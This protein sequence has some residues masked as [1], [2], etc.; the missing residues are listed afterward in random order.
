MR[1]AQR[2]PK[3]CLVRRDVR[4]VRADASL[5]HLPHRRCRLVRCV[6]C[7]AD[8][9]PPAAVAP[10]VPAAPPVSGRR[11][12]ARASSVP[13]LPSA[14]AA[15][16][17]VPPP[18]PSSAY[19]PGRGGIPRV[20]VR[21]SLRCAPCPR[22]PPPH[23]TQLTSPCVC[24]D[25]VVAAA[26]AASTVEN[27]S[28]PLHGL[29][30]HSPGGAPS[31]PSQPAPQHAPHVSHSAHA[32]HAAERADWQRRNAALEA[33]AARLRAALVERDG[34]VTELEARVA[35]LEEEV[36]GHSVDHTCRICEDRPIESVLVPCGHLCM[37]ATCWTAIAERDR[38]C[39]IC[40]Q[41]VD[42]AVR[43]FRA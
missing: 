23:L 5:L 42:S 38:T 21:E 31:P 22:V 8:G 25:V 7:A 11:R 32:A 16:A 24:D 6:S 35:A 1:D 33:E 43:I 14:N 4:V 41:A 9:F 40:R 19:G 26:V 34:R 28:S 39:P 10:G 3:L 27:P 13:A 18:A 20:S 30:L 2:L 29:T 36:E 37:C 17:V 12:A 15:D